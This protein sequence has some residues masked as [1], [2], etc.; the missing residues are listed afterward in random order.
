VGD[1]GGVGGGEEKLGEML[2]VGWEGGWW[3]GAGG[4]LACCGCGIGISISISIGI[5]IGITITI[6]IR[7]AASVESIANATSDFLSS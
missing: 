6:N 2:G 7:K 1:K 5:G 3:C 4:G